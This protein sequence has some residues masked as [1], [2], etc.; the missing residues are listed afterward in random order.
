M[1]ILVG[2]FSFLSFSLVKGKDDNVY[3]GITMAFLLTSIIYIIS[4][5]LVFFEKQ[6]RRSHNAHLLVF[7]IV[8]TVIIILQEV[9]Y[10]AG[11]F[12]ENFVKYSNNTNGENYSKNEIL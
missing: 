8:I 7:I 4:G 12:S 2:F 11:S 6:D 1:F 10:I 5:S 9:T 3:F